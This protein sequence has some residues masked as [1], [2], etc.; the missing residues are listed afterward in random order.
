MSPGDPVEVEL[1]PPEDVPN[2]VRGELLCGKLV[3]IEPSEAE[4]TEAPADRDRVYVVEID[5]KERRF[6]A[7]MQDDS[8]SQSGVERCRQVL[9]DFREVGV[10][11]HRRPH[12]RNPT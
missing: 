7:A 12:D 11:C 5:G 9:L 10:T 2:T 3:R 8:R 4:K 1:N 6:Q